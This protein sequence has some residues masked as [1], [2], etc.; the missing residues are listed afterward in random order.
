MVIRMMTARQVDALRL[1]PVWVEWDEQTK[2][3]NGRAGSAPGHLLRRAPGADAERGQAPA[4]GEDRH[5]PPDEVAHRR[6]PA[7]DRQRAVRAPARVSPTAVHDQVVGA[8]SA[9]VKEAYT[10]AM[11]RKLY[12][13]A[14]YVSTNEFEYFAELTCA[15]FDQFATTSPRT[16]RRPEEARPGVVQADGGGVGEGQEG[17]GGQGRPAGR[18][19]GRQ[20]RPGGAARRPAVRGAARR[21]AEADAGRPEGAG[22]PSSPTSPPTTTRCSQSWP[23]STASCR[24]TAC[25]PPPAARGWCRRRS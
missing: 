23:T 20:V 16:P 24:P 11:E 2:L 8:D 1:L 19:R 25:S 13:K 12:D 18:H 17:G 22:W 3:G 7:E 4:Q 14:Q 21:R 10:Q 15:Y 5:R 9:A 6:A